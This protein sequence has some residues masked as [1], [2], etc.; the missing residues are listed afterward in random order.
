MVSYYEDENLCSQY[1]T[2]VKLS[3]GSKR[4]KLLKELCK[5]KTAAA[6]EFWR[7]K[8]RD[9][10]YLPYIMMC[11]SN[12]FSDYLANRL[13]DLLERLISGMNPSDAVNEAYFLLHTCLFKESDKLFAAYG[14]LAS[15]YKLITDMGIGWASDDII[16][17]KSQPD[18]LMQGISLNV[19]LM[20]K[21]RFSASSPTR[22]S[23][24]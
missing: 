23:S 13:N 1:V 8:I 4:K 2:D 5:F 12:E 10:S 3:F 16:S 6:D 17:E 19:I 9:E 24:P 7:E 15:K 20:R 14:R 11:R 21:A 18:F 22:L